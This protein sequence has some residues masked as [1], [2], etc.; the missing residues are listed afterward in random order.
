[1]KNS[2]EFMK[3]IEQII[4]SCK[5]VLVVL[6]KS[7]EEATQV[8]TDA[9]DLFK[10]DIADK[11]KVVEK[12]RE[13]LEVELATLQECETSMKDKYAAIVT[14]ETLEEIKHFEVELKAINGDIAFC[15][16]RIEVLNGSSANG[17]K[18]LFE[19]AFAAYKKKMW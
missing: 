8:F 11:Q 7:N 19:K 12:K 17:D 1:M 4:E 3:S 5:Q 2:N 15:K 14:S 13:E 9:R 18:K 10:K 16:S 6:N